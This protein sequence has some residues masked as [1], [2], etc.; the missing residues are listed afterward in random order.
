MG[1][2]LKMQGHET[3]MAHDGDEAVQR[4]LEFDPDVILLDI[5]LPKLDGYDACRAIRKH[6][7]GRQPVVIALTGWGQEEDRRKSREAGFDSHLVKPV[8][9]QAL[10]TMIESLSPSR[11]A[12]ASIDSPTG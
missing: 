3:L 1:M 6:R 5:G 11:S 10:V 7:L 12:D 9:Y 8:D 2:L 4:A